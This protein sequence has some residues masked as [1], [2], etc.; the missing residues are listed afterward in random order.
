MLHVQNIS[1]DDSVISLHYIED[2]ILH[3]RKRY[4]R[5]MLDLAVRNIGT[6][7]LFL[8]ELLRDLND[9]TNGDNADITFVQTQ[10]SQ[11]A[12]VYSV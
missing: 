12:F 6:S 2:Y 9:C 7:S 4:G 5:P 8:A 3:R 11:V 1:I 10:K